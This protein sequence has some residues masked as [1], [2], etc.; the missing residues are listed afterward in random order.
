MGLGS[1]HS[2]RML[3]LVLVMRL[4]RKALLL[5]IHMIPLSLPGTSPCSLT[6]TLRL[7]LLLLLLLMVGSRVTGL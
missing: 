4:G 5:S 3:A 7:L 6:L 1:D 2:T